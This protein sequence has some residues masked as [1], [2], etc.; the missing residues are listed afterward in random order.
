MSITGRVNLVTNPT[1]FVAPTELG[2]GAPTPGFIP[3]TKSGFVV[4]MNGRLL[5]DFPVSGSAN[6]STENGNFIP[7]DF[8]RSSP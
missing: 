7:P 6:V 8:P 1:G 2:A 5:G 4:R 3:S